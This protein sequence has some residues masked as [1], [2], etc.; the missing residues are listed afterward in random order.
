MTIDEAY[1]LVNY[2]ANKEQKGEI[3][4]DEFNLLAIQAQLEAIMTR[5]G[6]QKRL[7]DRFIPPTG[8]KV[9]QQAKEEILPLITKSPAL[10]PASGIAPYPIDYF[11]YDN[12]QRVDGTPITIVESDQLGRIKK[13]YI[14]P[15]IESDPFCCFHSNGIELAPGT[16]SDAYLYYVRRP[17]NPNWD[18]T[19]SQQVYVY[20]SGS[21]PQLSG[22]V[23][24]NFEVAERLHKEICMIILKYVG[25]NLSDD[26]LT[27]FATRVQETNP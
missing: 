6:N 16:L 22:K 26:R 25:V 12:V 10:V 21:T 17:V 1:R 7:N 15:P 20:N 4:P 5:L 11:G 23:S 8:Y 18:Y 2:V 3:K 13:S 24:Q 9:N 14:T 19:V 27:E